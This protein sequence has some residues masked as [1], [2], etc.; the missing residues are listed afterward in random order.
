[1]RLAMT[2]DS[3]GKGDRKSPPQLLKMAMLDESKQR[4]REHIR[5]QF[6]IF[7]EIANFSCHSAIF[8]P[9]PTSFALKNSLDKKRPDTCDRNCA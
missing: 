3:N 6:V 5:H 4:R 2:V 1:M 8:L 7:D 9:A